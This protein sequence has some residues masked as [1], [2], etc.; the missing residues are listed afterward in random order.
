V[1]DIPRVFFLDGPKL[2]LT[3]KFPTVLLAVLVRV[4]MLVVLSTSSFVYI[5]CYY[6]LGGNDDLRNRVWLTLFG[7]LTVGNVSAGIIQYDIYSLGGS[8]YRYDYSVSGFSF[9]ANQLLDIRFD[10][11]LYSTLSKEVAPAG[12]VAILLQ[13][14]NPPG[15]SGDYKALALV[16]NPAL[17]GLFSVEWVYLGSGT[18]GSQPF[19]VDQYDDRGFFQYTTTAGMT[20][21][22]VLH[23]SEAP[24]PLSFPLVGAALTSGWL[25]MVRPWRRSR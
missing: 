11:S 21:A 24:E 23:A 19:F 22:N 17:A 2:T 16:D 4:H 6:Y 1:A 20:T 25:W 18:P 3:P 9:Q 12:F 14:N 15:D 10:P 8:S 5:H 13:P 7:L